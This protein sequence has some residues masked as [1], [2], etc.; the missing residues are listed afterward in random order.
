[1]NIKDCVQAWLNNEILEYTTTLNVVFED[2]MIL[3]SKEVLFPV[4][5]VLIQF[6]NYNQPRVKIE[7][8]KDADEEIRQKYKEAFEIREKLGEDKFQLSNLIG[9]EIPILKRKSS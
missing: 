1:V 3:S 4:K 5:I 9:Q 7:M 8:V 2:T 6:D